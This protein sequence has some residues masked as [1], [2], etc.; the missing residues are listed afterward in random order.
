MLGCDFH[1]SYCQ[2]WVSSQALRDPAADVAVG[3]WR[4]VTPDELVGYA[5][6]MGAQVI[7]SSYNEPLI[8][9][10][11]SAA[12]FDKAVKE[13]F[14]CAYVSNGNATE[15][16]LEYLSP[17]LD[18]LKVDLKSMQD[19]N[20]RKLG[21]VLQ[22]VLDTIEMAHRRG[23]WVE[24]VTLIVPGFNDSNEELMDAACFIASVSADI[25]WHV[26]AFHSDY[27][28]ADR[29]RTNQNTLRRAAEIGEEAGLNYVYAGNLP[30]QV[31]NYEDTRCPN[32]NRTLISRRG[33]IILDYALTN[34][35]NCPSCGTHIPG[36]WPDKQSDVRLGSDADW[37]FRRPRL[38]S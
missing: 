23:L 34:D 10:E 8:T 16:V 17:Y 36:I 3:H 2:N 11:W 22:H 21:G 25:P 35:G 37:L 29:G 28:M 4:R 13:G 1:C 24:V 18:A 15:E 38:V 9:S 33:F 32:C 7:A 27:K 12:I 26:T 20:Y 6:R 31:Q 5:R 19:A 30:G 14:K